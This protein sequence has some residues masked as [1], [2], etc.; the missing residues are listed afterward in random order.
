[1][2]SLVLNGSRASSELIQEKGFDFQHPTLESAL[3]NLY[4][5]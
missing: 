2:A 4:E 1:M 5:K 3:K